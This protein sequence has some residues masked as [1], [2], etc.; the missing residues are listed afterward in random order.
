M[1][2]RTFIE[3]SAAVVAGAGALAVGRLAAPA[4]A[5]PAASRTL[6]LIPRAGLADLD[7]T[8][9]ADYVVQCRGA[10]LGHALWRGP[11]AQIPAPDDRGRGG[12]GAGPHLDIPAPGRPQVS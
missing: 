2:R 4:R 11:R 7:P 5:Q 10:G 6:R 8:S 12:L 3:A 1:N 9:H